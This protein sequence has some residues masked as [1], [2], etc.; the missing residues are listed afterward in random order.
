LTVIRLAGY[1]PGMKSAALSLLL[2][3]ALAPAAA[4]DA[5]PLGTDIGRDA[6]ELIGAGWTGTPVSLSAVR[7]NTVVLAFWNADIP[8]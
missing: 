1:A 3:C 7:G 5:N 6:P 2:A 4:T 8:C